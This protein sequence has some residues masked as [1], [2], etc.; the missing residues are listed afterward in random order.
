M[1][2]SPGR[3]D[4][5]AERMRKDRQPYRKARNVRVVLALTE[6]TEH[7]H[8][9]LGRLVCAAEGRGSWPWWEVFVSKLNLLPSTS[10][11][12]QHFGFLHLLIF[13]IQ[14]SMGHL[15]LDYRKALPTH[16]V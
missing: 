3:P 9:N 12:S 4:W 7:S 15:W 16:R 13:F 8:P 14:W 10:A 2:L 6:G 1:W 11:A 5:G